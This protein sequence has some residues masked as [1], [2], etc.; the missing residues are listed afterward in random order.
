MLH[1]PDVA[2]RAD[3]AKPNWGPRQLAYGDLVAAQPTALP[4][5]PSRAYALD[6][7][8]DMASYVWSIND[9]VWPN[10]DPLTVRPGERVEVTM[11]NRTGMWHPM[12]LHGH[13]F[14]LLD[15]GAAPDLAPLKHTVSLPPNGKVRVEFLADNPGRW[16]FHCHNLYHMETGMAREWLYTV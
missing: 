12:H 10:A 11:T 16:F 13:F 4:G 2:P 8:G 15:T 14:R 9:Q 5:G 1:T 6:L 7:T 3:S